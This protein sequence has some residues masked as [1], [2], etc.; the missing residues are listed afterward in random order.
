MQKAGNYFN[1]IR[2]QDSSPEQ[3]SN[4]ILQAVTTDNP[5]LRYTV[6]E[7]TLPKIYKQK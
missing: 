7:D 6:G 2:E 5:Q 4:V 3:V 1:S